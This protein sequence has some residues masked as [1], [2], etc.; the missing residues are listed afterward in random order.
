MNKKNHKKGW[1]KVVGIRFFMYLKIKKK[2]KKYKL[3]INH[4]LLIAIV[5]MFLTLK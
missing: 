4:K 5:Q 2:Q 3:N 1:K